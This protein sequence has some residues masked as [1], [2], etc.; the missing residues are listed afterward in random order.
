MRQAFDRCGPSAAAAASAGF[1]SSA[2]SAATAPGDARSHGRRKA[3][4]PARPTATS[5]SQPAKVTTVGDFVCAPF[6]G[7]VDQQE[8]LWKSKRQLHLLPDI[9]AAMMGWDS[10]P[11]KETPFFWSDNTPEKFRDLCRRA[12]AVM[13]AAAAGDPVEKTRSFSA[14]GMS[15]ARATTSSPPAAMDSPT[16]TSS[17]TCSAR[18]RRPGDVAPEDVGLA[19]YDSW[20]SAI[21]QAAYV[22]TQNRCAQTH[23]K[24][25]TLSGGNR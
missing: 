9:T 20:Y 25:T 12:K 10:R 15:S 1:T 5:G 2:A 14:A 24:A 17:A 22:R 8:P 3:G 18:G 7:F 11:W 19:P 16:S 13:D 6:E 21:R 4:T 23:G